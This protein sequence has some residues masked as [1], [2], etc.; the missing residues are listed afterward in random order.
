MSCMATQ[1]ELLQASVTLQ[2]PNHH[3]GGAGSQISEVP[4]QP[5]RDLEWVHGDGV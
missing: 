4:T 2:L 1:T 5:S 3:T